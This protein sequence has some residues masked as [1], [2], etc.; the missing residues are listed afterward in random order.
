MNLIRTI[1]NLFVFLVF[2]GERYAKKIGVNIGAGCRIYTRHFGSEPYLVEIGDHV[3]LTQTVRFVTHDGAA[4]LI[5]DDKGRRFKYA[6]IKIGSNVF[7]G[8]NTVILPGVI[9]GDNVIVAAG[10]IVN[11]NILS[12]SV[13]GGVPARLICSF[14]DYKNRVLNDYMSQSEVDLNGGLSEELIKN[15]CK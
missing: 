4:W 14:S 2:G 10:S 3:T 6:R 13:V 9:I 1:V 15:N 11:K 12:N 7:I 8:L 5:R